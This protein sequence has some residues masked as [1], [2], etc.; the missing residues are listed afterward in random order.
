MSN[1]DN[2]Q[3]PALHAVGAGA[4]PSVEAELAPMPLPPPRV[5]TSPLSAAENA[6]FAS[7]PTSPRG[8]LAGV[9]AMHPYITSLDELAL[10]EEEPDRSPEELMEVDYASFTDN[11]KEFT[12]RYLRFDVHER[13]SKVLPA[14]LLAPLQ[15]DLD[16][17][18]LLPPIEEP[19]EGVEVEGEI[20][21][22]GER[23]QWRIEGFTGEFR[24]FFEEL[25][26]RAADL[27]DALFKHFNVPEKSYIGVSTIPVYLQAEQAYADLVSAKVASGEIPD[28]FA[29]HPPPPLHVPATY[30][31][32]IGLTFAS[33]T[34]GAGAGAGVQP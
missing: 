4:L 6:D 14:A 20:P 32:L 33:P 23:T 2:P 27:T 25:D 28:F 24:A 9:Q 30:A 13:L 26:V 7:A 29:A 5:E 16:V 15:T 1:P 19:E 22:A 10:P 3:K 34:A 8:F 11:E 21:T 17:E 18:R 31:E 12:V